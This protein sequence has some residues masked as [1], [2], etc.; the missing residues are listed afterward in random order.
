MSVSAS[1]SSTPHVCLSAARAVLPAWIHI[2][3]LCVMMCVVI[4]CLRGGYSLLVH[5]PL[6]D[7]AR[8]E[9]SVTVEAG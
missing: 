3:R 7:S 2:L 5:L 1:A 9:R 6:Y 4:S 8:D